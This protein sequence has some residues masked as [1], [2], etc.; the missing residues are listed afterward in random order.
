MPRKGKGKGNTTR[1]ANGNNTGRANGNG[2]GG[3]GGGSA[4]A[5]VPL[6]V[7]VVA[8]GNGGGGRA[9]PVPL[10]VPVVAN[11]N[12]GGG[13]AAPAPVPPPPPVVEQDL[14]IEE[15]N[16]YIQ[17]WI[18]EVFM[19]GVQR[20]QRAV[21][22]KLSFSAD[23]TTPRAI[24]TIPK[25]DAEIQF[26]SEKFH[27]TLRL[28]TF[29]RLI[30][31]LSHEKEFTDLETR[32]TGIIQ[33]IK[34]ELYLKLSSG[35]VRGSVDARGRRGSVTCS[36]ELSRV[37]FVGLKGTAHWGGWAEIS[38]VSIL[39][40]IKYF[41]FLG[42]TQYLQCRR[43]TSQ[44]EFDSAETLAFKGPGNSKLT[45]L[46]MSNRAHSFGYVRDY[47]G[48]WLNADDVHGVLIPRVPSVPPSWTTPGMFNPIETYP[49]TAMIFV[50][51]PSTNA[52]IHY[53][54][55]RLTANVT[56]NLFSTEQLKAPERLDAFRRFALELSSH[57]FIG[58]PLFVQGGSGTCVA[59]ALSSVLAFSDGL[60]YVTHTLYVDHILDIIN[61]FPLAGFSNRD[62]VIEC[63]YRI[64]SRLFGLKQR[65]SATSET[66]VAMDGYIRG[67][68]AAGAGG[69]ILPA[70]AQNITFHVRQN[71]LQQNPGGGVSQSH[72]L[73]VM[74]PLPALDSGTQ[75]ISLEYQART[76]NYYALVFIRLHFLR[77]EAGP[78]T[79]APARVAMMAQLG[80][81]QNTMGPHPPNAGGGGGG[82]I[83]MRNIH[84]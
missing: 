52:I 73:W 76:L 51:M 60:M 39:S 8:N 34:D 28:F 13:G 75:G 70:G 7:P 3:G 81:S 48:N 54:G 12:G 65:I 45:G 18:T 26:I 64:A 77:L 59:D 62:Q 56:S 71:I 30:A 82:G 72:R 47:T 80:I 40:T 17:A 1:R 41:N 21:A 9:A 63:C 27:T 36:A 68:H 78:P 32:Y 31:L 38:I 4:S 23:P 2:G 16:K 58:H 22:L 66:Q 29:S 79:T 25:M 46:I 15:T 83:N 5:P 53:E 24:E 49:T 44:A 61:S 10:P 42:L 43:V 33:I 69:N 84:E 67:T 37:L 11:G 55:G 50:S 6:P 20:H 57:P 19:P 74:E 14:H 35:L